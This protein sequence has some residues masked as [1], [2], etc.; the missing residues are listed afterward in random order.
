VILKSKE[1]WV[2][3]T[4]NKHDTVILPQLSEAREIPR[5]SGAREPLKVNVYERVSKQVAQLVPIFPYDDAGAIVPCA[6]VMWGGPEREHGQYF[7]WNTA[8]EVVITWGSNNAMLSTGQIMATQKYHGVNSFL[9]DEKDPEAFVI[10]TVTQR[11]STEEGQKEAM[12]AKCQ[13]CKQEMIRH[14]YDAGPF[15]APDFDPARFGR[16]DDFIRQFSTQAG[17]SEFAAIRNSAE[18]RTCPG[19]GFENVPLPTEP[20]NWTR[21]VKQTRIVN[22]AYHA[23]T[24]A[25]EA[26]RTA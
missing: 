17:S 13:E 25:A 16:E 11:Q 8:S 4:T 12:V 14:E 9:K 10:V 5:P 6:A 21:M 20:W 1:I 24:A 22:S 15:G 26:E 18:G 3:L 2:S 19:C 7:H 23:L